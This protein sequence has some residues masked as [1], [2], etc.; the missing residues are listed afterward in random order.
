[1]P[2]DIALALARQANAK[3]QAGNDAVTNLPIVCLWATVGLVLAGLLSSFG[4]DAAAA[5]ALVVGG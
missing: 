3:T 2:T 4:F 1:M 5:A